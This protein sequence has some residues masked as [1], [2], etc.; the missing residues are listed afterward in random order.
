M[1]GTAAAAGMHPFSSSHAYWL[2]SEKSTLV[3]ARMQ[4]KAAMPADHPR[5]SVVWVVGLVAWVVGLVVWVVGLVVVEGSFVAEVVERLKV[6]AFAQKVVKQAEGLVADSSDDLIIAGEGEVEV[7]GLMVKFLIQAPFLFIVL[8]LLPLFF[9]T[10]LLLCQ[11]P[12][13]SQ[14]NCRE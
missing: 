3:M 6:V 9:C 2:V 5:R 12:Q 8:T 13:T 4:L 1:G 14:H 7:V 11:D 10:F